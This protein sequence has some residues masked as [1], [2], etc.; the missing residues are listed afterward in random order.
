MPVFVPLPWCFYCC[1]SVVQFKIGDG[2]VS[3]SSLIFQKC[4]GY[5]GV[6]VYVC[7]FTYKAENCPFKFCEE[8]CRDF[9]GDCIESIDCFS[10][11]TIFTILILLIH[12]Y[13]RPLYI[14]VSSFSFFSVLKFLWEVFHFHLELPQFYIFGGFCERCCFPDFS[15][16]ICHLYIGGLLIWMTSGRA[17][18]A[19]NFWASSPALRATDFCM[20]ILYCNTLLKVFIGFKGFLGGLFKQRYLD[21]FLSYVYPFDLL[22][23]FYCSS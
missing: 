20:F 22:Q 6:S 5:H 12:E 4:F 16:S 3:T 18:S 19:L 7:V 23:W 14:L 13:G 15:Q 2:D 1:S 8:L 17:V 10:R 21:F 11:V 9:D